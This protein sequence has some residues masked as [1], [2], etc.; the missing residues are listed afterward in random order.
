MSRR[1]V[2]HKEEIQ[3]VISLLLS[4]ETN[5]DMEIIFDKVLTPRE[6]ND[7]ARRYKVLKMIDE[8]KSYA[9]IMQETGMSSVTVSRLS[10]KC[11]YGFRKSSGIKKVKNKRSNMGYGRGKTLKYK[12]V[13][14]ATIR[15]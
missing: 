3:E 5:H 4:C 13:A 2:W 6:I 10:M 14:V 11:G 1:L 12:G 9:D 15:K 7:I 8:G